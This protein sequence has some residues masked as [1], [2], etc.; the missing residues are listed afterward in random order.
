MV[1]EIAEAIREL[2][3]SQEHE[4]IA[5]EQL[6]ALRRE[7]IAVGIKA[8]ADRLAKDE[9]AKSEIVRFSD[10]MAAL[11]PGLWLLTTIGKALQEAR[12]R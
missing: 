6:V 3:R 1:N 10:R 2:A 12:E 4:A 11:E 7:E 5:A 8:A 9:E